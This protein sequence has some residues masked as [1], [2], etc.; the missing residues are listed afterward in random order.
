MPW[1]PTRTHSFPISLPTFCSSFYHSPSLSMSLSHFILVLMSLSAFFPS[2]SAFSSLSAFSP[3]PPFSLT[4]NTYAHIHTHTADV[5]RSRLHSL[6]V[7]DSENVLSST[8]YKPFMITSTP[9]STEAWRRPR[10]ST[11]KIMAKNLLNVNYT[12]ENLTF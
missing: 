8:T 11:Y 12:R 1:A 3:S 5:I 10:R 7:A 2:P 6:Q 9:D 4:K